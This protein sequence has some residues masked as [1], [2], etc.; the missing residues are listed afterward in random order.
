MREYIKFIAGVLIFGTTGILSKH[1]DMPSAQIVVW[2]TWIAALALTAFLYSGGSRFDFMQMKRNWKPLIFSGLQLGFGWLFFHEAFKFAPVSIAMLINYLGPVMV[3]LASPFVLKERFNKIKAIGV[4]VAML[5]MYL[6]AG[7]LNGS[8]HVLGLLYAFL[9]AVSYAMLMLT[10]KKIQGVS[11]LELT[12]VQL[13]LSGLV[14]FLYGLVLQMPPVIPAGISLVAIL[15]L[16]LNNTALACFLFFSA[17]N[18]IPSQSSAL[19]SYIDPLAS[20]VLSALILGERLSG[21]QW[22]GA[23]LI[24]GGAIL[25]QV[26]GERRDAL[27]S[28]ND[29]V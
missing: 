14:M 26:F 23:I 18:K 16:S 3:I 13:A 29:R 2:R 28:C 9:S 20:L 6:V 10:N 24:F 15:V 12:I 4:A 1:I 8:V 17:M 22:I 25:G 21:M 11:G 19:L 7:N 27:R 5:G